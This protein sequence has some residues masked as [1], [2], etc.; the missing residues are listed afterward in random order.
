MKVMREETLLLRLGLMFRRIVAW[1]SPSSPAWW[2]KR[3]YIFARLCW[4]VAPF[5]RRNEGHFASLTIIT[6]LTLLM[7]MLEVVVEVALD[8]SRG[9]SLQP[10]LATWERSLA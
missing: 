3:A 1:S 4:S 8:S 6:C 2:P 5:H 10:G 9:S 7:L